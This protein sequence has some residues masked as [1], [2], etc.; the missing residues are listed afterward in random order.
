MQSKQAKQ[1][2]KSFTYYNPN[3]NNKNYNYQFRFNNEG[4]DLIAGESGNAYVW[5]PASVLHYDATEGT[6]DKLGTCLLYTSY[7][8]SRFFFMK[9]MICGG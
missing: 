6:I 7:I 5:T 4:E 1:I 3:T 8:M 2:D 9:P